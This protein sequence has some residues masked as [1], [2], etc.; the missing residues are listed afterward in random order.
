MGQPLYCSAA[1]AG[2]CVG[3]EALVMAP[4]TTRDSAVLP[5]M[6]AWLSSTGV[7][8]HSLLPLLPSLQSVSPQSTAALALGLLHNP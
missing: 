6:A 3:R 7:S 2:M 1:D 4:P 5:S 8:H